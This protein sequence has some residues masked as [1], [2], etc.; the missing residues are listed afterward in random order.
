MVGEVRWCVSQHFSAFRSSTF[1]LV[2]IVLVIVAA[3][4]GGEVKTP[5]VV[6]GRRGGGTSRTDD[7]DFRAG[8][9]GACALIC[10]L[11]GMTEIEAVGGAA[12]GP[13][14]GKTD[15]RHFR[16]LLSWH[17]DVVRM[18]GNNVIGVVRT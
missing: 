8:A 6:G 15:G 16:R 2:V 13:D 1:F 7:V 12:G 9:D 11:H 14:G 5:A 10:K 18:T 4:H 17:N 3:Y